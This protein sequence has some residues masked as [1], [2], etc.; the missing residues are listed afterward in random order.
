M[1]RYR[2]INLHT[3]LYIYTH[4]IITYILSIIN[5]ITL[6]FALVCIFLTNQLNEKPLLYRNT[7]GVIF[8]GKV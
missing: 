8:S 3:E 6:V 1:S 4:L 5:M 7:K 2:I